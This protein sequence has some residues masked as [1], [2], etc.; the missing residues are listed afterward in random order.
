ML[1]AQSAAASLVMADSGYTALHST[2]FHGRCYETLGLVINVDRIHRCRQMQEQNVKKDETS[3]FITKS[4]D[5]VSPP[6]MSKLGC[7]SMAT[8]TISSSVSIAKLEVAA[9]RANSLGECALRLATMRGECTRLISLLSKTAPG[10][11]FKRDDKFR[12]T[13]VHWLWVRFVDVMLEQ[14]DRRHFTERS[15]KSKY[16]FQN[17]C[18]C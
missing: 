7:K 8:D 5:T 10:A 11:L 2:V 13:P 9:I 16:H 6:P 4:N 1:Q 14:F 12:L 17:C 15:K 18:C 3:D